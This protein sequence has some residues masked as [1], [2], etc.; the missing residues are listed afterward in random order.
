MLITTYE[1]LLKDKVVLVNV[2]QMQCTMYS[3]LNHDIMLIAICEILLKNEVYYTILISECTQ[4]FLC[5]QISCNMELFV[6][7]EVDDLLAC[8]WLV[9]SEL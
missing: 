5:T 3:L 9:C 6:P 1:I 7:F 8:F 2:A 4:I